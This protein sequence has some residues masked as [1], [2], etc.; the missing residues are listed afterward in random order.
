MNKICYG[1]GAKLQCT[2]ELKI[3]YIPEKKIN[4]SKYCMRCFRM[5]HYG[6]NYSID[7]PKD[8]KEI[9][10][11]INNDSKFVI[12]LVDFLNISESVIKLFKSIKKKKLLL[13]NKC[14]LMP[15]SVNKERFVSFIA[16]H[17]SIIDP[18]RLKGGTKFHGAKSVYNFLTENNIKEAYIL[19]LSNS[20]KST[21]INDLARIND[22]N[23][24]SI[25]VSKRANT[26][27]DFIRTKISNDLVLIDSPGFIIDDSLNNDVTGKNIKEYS[28]NIKEC[29][30]VGLLDNKY[31]LKFDGKTQM[32]LYTNS[33]AER[34]VKKYYRAAPNLVYTINVTKPNTDI[35]IRGIGFITIKKCVNIT[36]NIDLKYIEVRDSMFGD[37][38]E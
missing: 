28:M 24:T 4:D 31:F 5:T 19:G 36:T 18:I 38:D 6:E 12:F 30:T 16:N 13:I 23:V 3:G 20:G 34:I 1:C 27:I 14:E 29:E 15:K 35:V 11:K 9:I 25:T 7:T 22:S 37:K 21:L 26:T 32:V 10:R 33:S 8:Q 2:D 17:Y